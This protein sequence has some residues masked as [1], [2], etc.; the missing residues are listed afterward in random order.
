M[1]LIKKITILS[2]ILGMG[3]LP[4]LA[5]IEIG[6]S[7][8]HFY[9]SEKT[10]M[11][12]ETPDKTVLTEKYWAN[13]P[14][15]FNKY[16]PLFMLSNKELYKVMPKNNIE[17]VQRIY[18][19]SVYNISLKNS[20][21]ITISL[22]QPKSTNPPSAAKPKTSVPV[23]KKEIKPEKIVA[24]A[25]ISDAKLIS[26]YEQAKNPGA[27]SETKINIAISLKESN[28]KSN[29]KLAIDLLDDV[30]KKEPYNAYAFY[31]KGEVYSK[32]KDSE[33]AIKNYVEALKLNPT[34]KQ[35]YLGIAKV[36]EPT[37]KK[38]AQKYY[39]KAGA[40]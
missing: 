18:A 36:L 6:I 33:N 1:R 13:N 24:K 11:T 16:R 10:I 21:I 35:C 2:F 37:N 31:L 9:D 8:S 15:Y 14:F 20:S 7:K 32:L 19:P 12:D 27:E 4:S 28:N 25:N 40:E 30:T 17:V 23:A 38:L 22:S 5:N 26:Q 3:V 29:C 34:S 39:D